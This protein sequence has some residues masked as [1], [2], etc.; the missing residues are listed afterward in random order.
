MVPYLIRP[1]VLGAAV[2][3]LVRAAAG[4]EKLRERVRGV[5]LHVVKA[6]A[7]RKRQV[8]QI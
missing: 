4:R 5:V 8:V 6:L 1:D 3:T 2:V 7:S